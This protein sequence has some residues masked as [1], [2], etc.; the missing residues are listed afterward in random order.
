MHISSII[1]FLILVFWRQFLPRVVLFVLVHVNEIDGHRKDDGGVVLGGNGVE[2]LQVAQLN[3]KFS[4]N[5]YFRAS[6]SHTL[7]LSDASAGLF[8]LVQI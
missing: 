5:G 3:K 6:L 8:N 2:R 1:R 7:C 4:C